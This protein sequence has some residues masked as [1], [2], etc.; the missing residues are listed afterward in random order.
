MR[1]IKTRS[2]PVIF[3]SGHATETPHA[4]YVRLSLEFTQ[5]NPIGAIVPTRFTLKA[6]VF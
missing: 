6:V 4:P 1:K 2:V 3:R 5:L